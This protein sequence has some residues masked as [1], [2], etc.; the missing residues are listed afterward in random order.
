[1][2]FKESAEMAAQ[3]FHDLGDLVD[4][5]GEEPA[6]PIST[7][8]KDKDLASAVT[9]II[10]PVMESMGKMMERVLQSMEQNAQALTV[11]NNRMEA[12]EKQIRLQTPITPKQAQYLNDAIRNKAREMLDK[13]DLSGNKWAV[14]KL[15]NAIRKDVLARYGITGLREIPRHE[16]QIAMNQIGMWG[17]ALVFRDIVK[18]ARERAEHAGQAAGVDGE[19]EISGQDNQPDQ[20]GGEKL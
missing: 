19:K 16:Y 10:R 3:A 2:G 17:N 18:E 1:M 12:L 13:R 4:K 8:Q 11:V 6:L 14:T 9:E 20:Q 7:Q 15:G 5:R